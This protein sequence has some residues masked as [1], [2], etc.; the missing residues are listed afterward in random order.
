VWEVDLVIDLV[1]YFGLDG[2]WQVVIKGQGGLGGW[3]G[4]GFDN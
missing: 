2:F 3:G 1:G 4:L